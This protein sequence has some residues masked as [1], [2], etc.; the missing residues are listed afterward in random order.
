MPQLYKLLEVIVD[1]DDDQL[2]ART[3]VLLSGRQ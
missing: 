3:V 1:V 2:W